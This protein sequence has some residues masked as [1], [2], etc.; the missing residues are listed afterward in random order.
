MEE[1]NKME[2]K[3]YSCSVNDFN[4]KISECFSEYFKTQGAWP[5]GPDGIYRNSYKIIYTNPNN[6]ERADVVPFSEKPI[7]DKNLIIFQNKV[8]IILRTDNSK[9]HKKLEDLLKE[10]KK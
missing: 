6:S 10:E 1:R 2:E 8:N 5:F 7:E 3:L 9:I 4:T